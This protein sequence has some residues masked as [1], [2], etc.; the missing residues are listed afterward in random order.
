MFYT[1]T[2]NWI[3]VSRDEEVHWSFSDAQ[4]IQFHR[5]ISA[6]V[7]R[8]DYRDFLHFCCVKANIPLW[9]EAVAVLFG[10][11]KRKLILLIWAGVDSINHRSFSHVLCL[12]ETCSLFSG[13]M[14]LNGGY[15]GKVFRRKLTFLCKKNAAKRSSNFTTI[16]NASKTRLCDE[17]KLLHPEKLTSVVCIPN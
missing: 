2:Q 17:F 5:C 12:W 4:Q 3:F 9:K 6:C 7:P 13:K 16:F 11:V 1:W 10:V 8:V 15:E 14:K